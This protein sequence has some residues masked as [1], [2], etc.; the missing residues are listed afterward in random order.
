MTYSEQAIA[1]LREKGRFEPQPHAEAGI[2]ADL[3]RDNV[4]VHIGK[5]VG[6][7]TGW[8]GPVFW[9]VWVEPYQ[10]GGRVFTRVDRGERQEL[11]LDAELALPD[12]LAAA[13]DRIVAAANEHRL[14][15]LQAAEAR[16]SALQAAAAIGA[17]RA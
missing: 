11:L 10:A 15:Q 9:Q 1:T 7:V 6:S 5:P 2:V 16:L 13:K 8:V 3:R 12:L 17:D 14:A 4:I